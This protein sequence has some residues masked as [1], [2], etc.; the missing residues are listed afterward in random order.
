MAYQNII[1]IFS[2]MEAMGKQDFLHLKTQTITYKTFSLEVR[3]VCQ[4]FEQKELKLGDKILIMSHQ[5]HV[6]ILF[7]FAS[8]RYGL[9]TIFINPESS[10]QQIKEIVRKTE[11]KALLLEEALGN[12]EGF[13][14]NWILKI[15]K[16]EVKKGKLF[17]KL[18]KKKS[19]HLTEEDKLAYPHILQDTAPIDKLPDTIPDTTLAYIL[20]TSGSTAQPKGVMITHEN[21]W[22]HIQTLSEAYHLDSKSVLLNNL[23]LYHTDGMM[24]GSILVAYCQAKLIRPLEKFKVSEIDSLLDAIYKYR[25]THFVSVPTMLRFIQHYSEGYEDS[26]QTEDFKFI[27]SSGALLEK[28]LW[29]SFQEQFKVKIANVYG[30]TETVVGSFFCGTNEDNYKLGTIGKTIDCEAKIINTDNEEVIL[31]EQGEL[32]LKGKHISKGYLGDENLNKESFIGEWFKTGDIALEDADGFF[33]IVGRKKNIVI[34]GGTNIQPEEVSEAI[35][36]HQDIVESACF[37][38]EDSFFGEKLIAVVVKKQSSNL[39]INLL[40][41]FLRTQLPD[42]KIPSEIIFSSHL[43]KGQTGKIDTNSIKENYKQTLK[44]KLEQSDLKTNILAIASKAFK[45][46]IANLTI[47]DDINSIQGWDSM[48]HLYLVTLMEES[49]NIQLSTVEVMKINSL[50]NA[51]QIVSKKRI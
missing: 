23:P 11:A 6:N 43:A 15:K 10:S 18:L 25:V 28:E 32:C 27:I 30:L 13:S 14:V 19:N 4:L 35:N 7:F 51:E 5:D 39:D 17:K 22:T 26:F 38:V 41:T 46:P 34:V 16:E 12:F 47:D 3:K 37:G 36:S 21:L 48:G 50:K 33:S 24:S 40:T 9:T 1:Q 42:A 2:K 8:L 49:F 20:F 31:G 45:E 29:K 44:P